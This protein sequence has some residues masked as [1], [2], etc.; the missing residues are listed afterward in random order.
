M[1]LIELKIP[2][3][4]ILSFTQKPY[5]VL[6]GLKTLGMSTMPVPVDGTGE[7]IYCYLRIFSSGFGIN[8]CTG[9]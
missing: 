3:A 8:S 1:S 5:L 6:L 7:K 9:F 2:N 4:L